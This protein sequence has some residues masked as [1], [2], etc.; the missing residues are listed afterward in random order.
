MPLDSTKSCFPYTKRSYG[1]GAT[2]TFETLKTQLAYFLCLLSRV[3]GHLSLAHAMIV[4]LSLCGSAALSAP[5][6]VHGI[7]A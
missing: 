6:L 4:Q 3:V 7:Q 1:N 2:T 5:N